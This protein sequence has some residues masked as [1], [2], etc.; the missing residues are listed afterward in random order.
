MADPNLQLTSQAVLHAVMD[1]VG[2]FIYIK[3]LEGRYL[4][5]NKKVQEL[6]CAP[7]IEI[8]GKTDEAFFDLEISNELR[9]VDRKVMESGQVQEC[10]ER[11]YVKESDEIRTYWSVKKPLFDDSGEIIGMFGIST[12]ITDRKRIERELHEQNEFLNIVMNNVESSIYMIDQDNKLRY[13]N[14]RLAE[15]FEIA[16]GRHHGTSIKKL[17]DDEAYQLITDNNQRVFESRKAARF[18][19][20]VKNA[21]GEDTI[22]WSVKVPHTLATGE[23]VIIGLSTDMTETFALQ[24]KLKRQS[25][26]DDLTGLY[27]R[28][29]F[30]EEGEKQLV[31]AKHQQEPSCMLVLDLDR[32]KEINDEHGHPAGDEALTQVARLLSEEVRKTDLLARVGGEEFALFLPN[33]EANVATELAEKLRQC[34]QENPVQIKPGT[35]TQLT[36]SVGVYTDPVSQ[37]PFSDIYHEAD[38]QLYEA[39]KQGRNRVASRSA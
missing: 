35:H 38:S 30:F 5:A 39:K 32:F 22:F 25:S 24:E 15:R 13:A 14:Q 29:Y 36:I 2:A 27:N 3:D 10:E 34:I 1:N 28:R 21:D 17:L 12:D 4:Y 31:E 8:Q 37:T 20:K 9:E 11:N 16:E 19:E 18:K 26:E 7:L 23:E 33:T 6:F